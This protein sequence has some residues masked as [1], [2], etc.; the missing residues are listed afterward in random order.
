MYV[1]GGKEDVYR[2]GMSVRAGKKE[3]ETQ[4]EEEEEGKFRIWIPRREGDAPLGTPEIRSKVASRSPL[5]WT[6]SYLV[7]YL[8]QLAA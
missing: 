6:P 4:E 3:Q 7:E 8:S 1:D 2:Q 5:T